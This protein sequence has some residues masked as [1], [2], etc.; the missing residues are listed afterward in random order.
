[1][2]E[3]AMAVAAMAVAP[4]AAHAAAA[5]VGAAACVLYAFEWRRFRGDWRLA[6]L[7]VLAAAAG[8]DVLALAAPESAR[9]AAFYGFVVFTLLAT[10]FASF[11]TRGS[12]SKPRL[13]LAAAALAF[14]GIARGTVPEE[15]L[16]GAAGVQ[17]GAAVVL[18]AGLCFFLFGLAAAEAS[19]RAVRSG[20]PKRDYA[21][22]FVLAAA[23]VG[24]EAAAFAG[25]FGGAGLGVAEL[26]AAVLDLAPP[27]FAIAAGSLVVAAAAARLREA[28]QGHRLRS[29]PAAYARDRGLGAD[30][31]ELLDAWLLGFPPAEIARSMGL[32]PAELRDRLRLVRRKCGARTRARVL[33]DMRPYLEGEAEAT[34][35]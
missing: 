19:F 1:M 18:A 23:R 25:L 35:A 34:W 6:F 28:A 3:A 4:M 22:F 24:A 9:K 16:D 11:L 12:I 30:E 7:A 8:W 27:I 10:I 15:A 26:G 5:L 21:P 2:T 17:P 20:Q 33:L 29:V 14:F 13:A 32:R 31:A